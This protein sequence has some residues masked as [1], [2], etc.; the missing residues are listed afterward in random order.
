VTGQWSSPFAAFGLVVSSKF[1]WWKPFDGF[2]DVL[3]RL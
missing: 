2:L 1:V 3:F